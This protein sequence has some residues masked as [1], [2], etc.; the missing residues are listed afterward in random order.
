MPKII[1]TITINHRDVKGKTKVLYRMRPPT[2]GKAC[3]LRTVCV[4]S[5][6][7]LF[8]LSATELV[9]DR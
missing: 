5:I 9:V 4:P 3:L 8:V 1:R 6:T 2:R 7:F